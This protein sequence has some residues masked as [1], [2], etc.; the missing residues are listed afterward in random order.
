MQIT[1]AVLRAPDA[2]HVLEQVELAPPGPG[3]V[4]VRIAG[5]GMCHTDVVPRAGGAFAATPIICGHEG[6]GVVEAIGEGVTSVA[7]G[8]HVVLSF[9]SCGY[10]ANC[11]AGV[12]AYCDT[13]LPRNL[14]GRS[15]DGSTGVT[16]ADGEPIGSRWFGQSSFA[17]HAVANE[18]NTVVVD[19]SLPIELL[20]PLGCGSRPAQQVCWWR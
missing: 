7:V 20:G 3:Q 5:A 8:D 17:T 18:R 4:L 2:P 14:L 6:S 12:P 13:M 1:A 15:L 16:G 10:C 19:R 9:D 11:L